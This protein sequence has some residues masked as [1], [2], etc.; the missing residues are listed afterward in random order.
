MFTRLIFKRRLLLFS[1]LL[2][3]FVSFWAS[4]T[5][6]QPIDASATFLQQLSLAEGE[7]YQANYIQYRKLK[8]MKKP[9]V[10]SGHLVINA[11]NG[12]LWQQL[13]PLKQTLIVTSKSVRQLDSDDADMSLPNAAEQMINAWAPMMQHVVLG[14]W[15]ELS[16]RFEILIAKDSSVEA[17][18]ILLKPIDQQMKNALLSIEL[19]GSTALDNIK[20]HQVNQDILTI[21]LLQAE[22]VTLSKQQ[23]SWLND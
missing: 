6:W 16:Q 22:P 10:S 21:Q 5:T 12:L 8:V 3:C 18:Q 4:A 15:S 9:L 7:H 14:E 23:L 2:M 19:S 17:W 1:P 13:K 11:E 20:M